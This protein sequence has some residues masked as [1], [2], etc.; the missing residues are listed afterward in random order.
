VVHRTINI[1]LTESVWL[2][3]GTLGARRILELV[4]AHIFIAYPEGVEHR[5]MVAPVRNIPGQHSAVA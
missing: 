2:E 4:T 5:R 3:W 1:S